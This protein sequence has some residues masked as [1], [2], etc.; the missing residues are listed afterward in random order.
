MGNSPRVLPSGKPGAVQMQ[1]QKLVYIAHGWM[2]GL[3]SEPLVDREPEAWERGPVFP[4]LREHIKLSGSKL[5]K[6]LIRENDDN[7]FAFFGDKNRCDVFAAKLV[8]DEK[9][10]Y[11]CVVP[12]WAHGRI[13]LVRLDSYAQHATVSN[14]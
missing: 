14:L 10:F 12:I 9:F 4:S 3:A 8:E 13:P 11:P 2:L 6:D 7:P 1:V 5:I